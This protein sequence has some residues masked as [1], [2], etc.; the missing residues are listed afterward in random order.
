[1]IYLTIFTKQNI[2]MFYL[3]AVC[4]A[5]V[6]FSKRAALK[7]II[8]Q[9]IIVFLLT[10]VTI[11]LM[12]F[13]GNLQGFLNYTILGMIDFTGNNLS[14]QDTVEMVI[15]VYG[16]IAIVSYIIA[17]L[18]LKSKEINDKNLIVLLIFAA[19]LNFSSYPIFN[20]YHTSFAILL[21]I[22]VFIYIFDKILLKKL[23]SKK[24]IIGLIAM[25][26]IVIN[27]F[28]IICGLKNIKN[29]KITDK[30]SVYYSANL[31]EELN[32]NLK[33]TTKYILQ[34]EKEGINVI[35]ISSDAALYMTALNKNNKE[36]DLIF[37]GNLGYK[38]KEKTLE[39]IKNLDNIEIL[40]NRNI[41]GQ[42]LTE[43][44]NYIIQNCE[45]IN[46]IGDCYV[47]KK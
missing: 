3:I 2:G 4:F 41:H 42:E 24:I 36:L 46:T 26:Y 15:V 23:I 12:W 35:C 6:Y 9:F 20:L 38:G 44:R 11:I 28:C 40:M 13:Q 17:F 30:N 22:I 8:K 14:I 1:M 19:L 47:F 16:V 10:L 43:L 45:R 5:E 37:E 31:S 7:N 33:E 39:K 32:N 29:I 27:I 25:I 18:L 21:N 34:K